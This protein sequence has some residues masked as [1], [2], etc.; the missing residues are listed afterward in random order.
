MKLF[1]DLELVFSPIETKDL[2]DEE[3]EALC[4][5]IEK[6]TAVLNYY[7]NLYKLF[8]YIEVGKG[9]E[10]YGLIGDALAESI[11][12]LLSLKIAIPKNKSI[13]DI[14]EE[15]EKFRC[16]I[17]REALNKTPKEI[18]HYFSKDPAN[19]IS[20]KESVKNKKLQSALEKYQTAITEIYAIKSLIEGTIYWVI[21]E[22][23]PSI[24]SKLEKFAQLSSLG[25]VIYVSESNDPYLLIDEIIISSLARKYE[26]HE[27]A[28][29]QFNNFL[30]EHINHLLGIVRD[31]PNTLAG[32]RIKEFIIDLYCAEET[33]QITKD[34][35]KAFLDKEIGD[36]YKAILGRIDNAGISSMLTFLYIFFSSEPFTDFNYGELHKIAIRS[37][38]KNAADMEVGRDY[39]SL[40]AQA[41]N[42]INHIA[43]A[44]NDEHFKWALGASM[45]PNTGKRKTPVFQLLYM[46]DSFGEERV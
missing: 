10:Y 22:S 41:F 37:I 5:E 31:Y 8:Q 14:S 11:C 2:S 36:R 45:E 26:R 12:K 38:I 17:M 28:E 21:N 16:K 46:T 27:L 33:K 13:K 15:D 6:Q 3:I 9:N 18:V 7:T 40:I 35:Y 30:S 4:Q 34:S 42:P 1:E 20:L 32:T 24:A 44:N 43:D 29:E 39:N 23:Y 19:I 25:K